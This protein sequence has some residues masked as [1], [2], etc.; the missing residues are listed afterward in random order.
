LGGLGT[1]VEVS[2]LEGLEGSNKPKS[3]ASLALAGSDINFN[4]S[5]GLLSN[6]NYHHHY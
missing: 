3:I 1:E 6:L 4:N 5:A 2:D